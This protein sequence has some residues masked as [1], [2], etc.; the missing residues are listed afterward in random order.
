[1]YAH[2]IN[3]LTIGGLWLENCVVMELCSVMMACPHW[4]DHSSDNKIKHHQLKEKMVRLQKDDAVREASREDAVCGLIRDVIIDRVEST[5]EM[6]KDVLT[7]NESVNVMCVV[8]L[9]IHSII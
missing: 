3:I 5:H 1:M 6:G 2:L 9:D 8:Y 7:T 4:S